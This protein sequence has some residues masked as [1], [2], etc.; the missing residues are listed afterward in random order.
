MERKNGEK[1]RERLPVGYEWR[2]QEAKRRNE[3]D[4]EGNDFEY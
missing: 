2:V 3:E 4:N 1:F